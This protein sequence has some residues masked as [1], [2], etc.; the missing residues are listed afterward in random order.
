MISKPIS[1]KKSQILNS[2]EW[3]S[4]EDIHTHLNEFIEDTNKEVDE[5]RKTMQDM[6]GEFNKDI[7]I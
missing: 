1:T 6:K 4:K 3:S 2:K 7:E 5:I